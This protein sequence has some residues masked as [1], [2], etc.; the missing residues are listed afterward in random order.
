MTK[1][2]GLYVKK[3]KTGDKVAL[4]KLEK[5]DAKFIQENFS[6]A[7]RDNSIEFIEDWIVKTASSLLF[8]ISYDDEKV[9]FISLA[10]KEEGVLNWGIAVKTGYERKGIAFRAFELAKQEARNIGYKK[11]VSSCSRDNI[12]SKKLHEK[13]GFGL[14]K[15]EINQ[16][17]KEMHRWELEI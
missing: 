12:A 1:N 13:C 17:G 7:F 16:A 9:G 4:F 11:I 2:S 14:I 3:G 10:K 5:E 15:T 6:F 8:G